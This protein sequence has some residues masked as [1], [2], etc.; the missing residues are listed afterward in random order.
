MS[1]T[2]DV[3]SSLHPPDPR[4]EARFDPAASAVILGANPRCVPVVAIASARRAARRE[5][6]SG[7]TARGRR[8]AAF[9]R[10]KAGIANSTTSS[11]LWAARADCRY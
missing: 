6:V 10:A 11:R 2:A 7:G 4:D 5:P 9:T 8:E 3:R 1:V